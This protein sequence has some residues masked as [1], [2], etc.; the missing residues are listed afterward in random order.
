MNI[1]R[2]TR[3]AAAAL[4][5]PATLTTKVAYSA[6]AG[7]SIR[8][9][10]ETRNVKAHWTAYTESM[11]RL[12]MPDRPRYAHIPDPGF[13]PAADD[14]LMIGSERMLITDVRRAPEGGVY[15]V[16]GHDADAEPET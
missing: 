1:G 13:A 3:A 15:Y 14:I 5:K 16:G 10:V 2:I 4:S 9:S 7:G 11:R 12:G 6:G 8:A